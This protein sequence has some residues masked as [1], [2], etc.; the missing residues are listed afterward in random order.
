MLEINKIY[1]EDCLEGMKKIDDESIDCIICDLPYGT[2]K[3]SWDS[4]ISL[5]SLWFE[6]KRIIKPYGRF[7]TFE[8]SIRFF[9][10]NLMI[11][12]KMKDKGI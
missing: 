9:L 7:H 3:N 10:L 8:N 4:V 12:Y 2:T 6:Y 11:N 1:N 5:D